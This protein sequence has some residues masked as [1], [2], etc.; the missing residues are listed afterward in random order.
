MQ[1][2]ITFTSDRID[3]T[4]ILHL[5]DGLLAGERRSAVL[6]LHGFGGTKDDASH[7]AEAEYYE[8]LGYVVLRFD[9]RGC[10]Q[11]AGTPGR[12]LC[13]DQVTDVRNALTW[14]AARREVAPNRLLVSGQGL[15]GAVAIYAAGID[16]R[17][18]AVVSIG[19]WGNGERKFR[20]HHPSAQAWQR[21]VAR[22]DE[23]RQALA[24][25]QSVS[26]ARWDIIPVPTGLRALLPPGAVTRFPVETVLSM[27]EF[28]PE[29]L[30]DRIAPRPLLIVHGVRD[31]LTPT[32]EALALFRR[33]G[34]SAE[35]LVMN[36]LDQFPFVGCDQRLPLHLTG[37]LAHNLPPGRDGSLCLGASHA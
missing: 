14:L 22:L 10:G 12:A 9:M 26:M 3:L 29:E 36:G 32:E 15:G 18:A 1:R 8:Q 17:I 37:W 6:V 28:R 27:V 13:L 25:G 4:G 16:A 7:Q 24:R 5:P 2:Q 21:F 11:S 19:G 30:V 31:A 23:G 34:D 20:H 33:A 35:L